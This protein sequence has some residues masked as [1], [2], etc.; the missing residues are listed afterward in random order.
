MVAAHP[1]HLCIELFKYCK[2]EALDATNL[3]RQSKFKPVAVKPSNVFEY[4]RWVL[5]MDSLGEQ[6]APEG[7]VEKSIFRRH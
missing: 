1:F 7:K 4:G 6:I 2:A 3:R 5:I